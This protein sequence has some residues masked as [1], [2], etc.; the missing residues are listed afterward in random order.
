MHFMM[1]DGPA[2]VSIFMQMLPKNFQT[3]SH[4]HILSRRVNYITSAYFLASFG[5]AIGD[6]SLL[7]FSASAVSCS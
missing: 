1:D 5:A 7:I 6:L 4:F 3:T 2:N